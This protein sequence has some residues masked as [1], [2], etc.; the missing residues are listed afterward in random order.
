MEATISVME[1]RSFTA[2]TDVFNIVGEAER[3]ILYLANEN[4]S[5][6]AVTTQYLISLGRS[7]GLGP[8]I[9]KV[10]DASEAEPPTAGTYDVKVTGRLLGRNARAFL[11][12]QG[13]S[14]AFPLSV[15]SP[16]SGIFLSSGSGYVVAPSPPLTLAPKG[17][18]AITV[19]PP[20]GSVDMLMMMSVV[21]EFFHPPGTVESHP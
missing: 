1:G 19:K 5:M 4:P 17:A 16:R 14:G 10:H 8:A 21:V 18:L 9:I 15:D 7:V 3:T 6:Y 20:V 13:G 2:L 12:A 11:R